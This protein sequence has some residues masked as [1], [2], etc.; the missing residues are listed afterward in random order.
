MQDANYAMS[1]SGED[2]GGVKDV[3][4]GRTNGEQKQLLLVALR[5]S[6]QVLT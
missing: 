6:M 4:I 5:Q 1:G 3:L 2:T